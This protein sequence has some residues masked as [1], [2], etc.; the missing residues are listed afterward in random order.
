MI[1]S[2]EPIEREAGAA[3]R[4]SGVGAPADHPRHVVLVGLMGAGKT[5]VGRRLAAALE[6][7]FSDSD[8]WIERRTGR[9]VRELRD[10]RGVVAM[11][12][13]EAAHLRDALGQ[14]QPSVIAAAASTIEDPGCREALG[15]PGVAV[16]WL[17]AS[18]A[19]LAGRFVR[20]GHRPWYG[21]RPGGFLAD[22]AARRDPLYSALDPI[23]VETEG[24]STR[25]VVGRVLAA[26]AARD[27]R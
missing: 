16:V 2:R 4:T 18:P 24:T 12:E 5:T 23:P 9:T 17:R 22:Q 19:A 10:E 21:R 20:K 6:R 7:P 1:D 26:L 14:P 27:R 8:P 13:L 15:A 25:N 3:S 11:H